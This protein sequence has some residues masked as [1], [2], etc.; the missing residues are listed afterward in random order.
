MAPRAAEKR[1]TWTIGAALVAGV[2]AG[3]LATV[4]HA[5]DQLERQREALRGAGP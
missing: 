4:G 2:V 1:T 3:A 5:E